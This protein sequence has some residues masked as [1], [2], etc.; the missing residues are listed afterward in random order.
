MRGQD[1]LLQLGPVGGMDLLLPELRH[2]RPP[3]PA[4][5]PGAGGSHGGAAKPAEL[6]EKFQLI[7]QLKAA[8]GRRHLDLAAAFVAGMAVFG[9]FAGLVTLAIRRAPRQRSLLRP[10]A[11]DLTP[12]D[13][14]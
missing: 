4:P 11:E 12:A 8:S 5:V 2:Q 14:A 3:A 1:L 7:S 13:Q 10:L 6:A 9:S